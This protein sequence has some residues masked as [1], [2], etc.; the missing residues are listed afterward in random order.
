MNSFYKEPV[1]PPSTGILVPEIYDAFRRL[2]KM[3]YIMSS[4]VPS[5]CNSTELIIFLISATGFCF[6]DMFSI[7]LDNP[8]IWAR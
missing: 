1:L 3:L 2:K 8:G 7:K 6:F 5:L 4:T